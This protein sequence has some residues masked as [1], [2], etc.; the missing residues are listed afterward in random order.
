M[1]WII[2]GMILM[3]IYW[4]VGVPVAIAYT[5]YKNG[6]IQKKNEEME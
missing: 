2:Y 6:R 3:I 5:M 4:V 1:Q